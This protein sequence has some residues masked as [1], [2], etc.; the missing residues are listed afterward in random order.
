MPSSRPR[1][2]RYGTRAQR[3][4]VKGDGTLQPGTVIATF[5]PG[6]HYGNHLDGRS[7]AAVYVGQNAAGILVLDQWHGHKKQPVHQRLIRFKAG[8]GSK[9]DDGDQFYVAE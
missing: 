8:H 1:Q 5:D 3:S 4:K 6:G 9:V 7:H 2:R